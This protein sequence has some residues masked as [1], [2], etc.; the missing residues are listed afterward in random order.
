MNGKK[1]GDINM[2]EGGHK[3]L[4]ICNEI[5]LTHVSYLG[6]S[7]F[8]AGFCSITYLY[9]I[10]GWTFSFHMEKLTLRDRY[11]LNAIS[12][13]ETQIQTWDFVRCFSKKREQCKIVHNQGPYL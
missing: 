3:V 4:K 6:V 5:E 1:L 8:V 12:Y 7:H 13:L 11:K 2:F 9:H 10:P